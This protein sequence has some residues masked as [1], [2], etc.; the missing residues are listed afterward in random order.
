M[1]EAFALAF[2]REE[3]M[4]LWPLAFGGLWGIVGM[5]IAVPLFAVIYNSV[6]RL[7]KRG[8]IKK[9]QNEIW[10]QYKAD[11]PDEEPKKK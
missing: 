3:E 1:I 10:D 5:V 7:V 4:A 8:L 9:E 11:Y 2:L 6:K